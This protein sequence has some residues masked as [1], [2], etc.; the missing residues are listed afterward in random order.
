MNIRSIE[1]T[2]FENLTALSIQVWLHTY[3]KN[4]V[5]KDMAQY[6]LT[7]FTPEYFESIYYA[8][9]QKLYVATEDDHLIGFITIDLDASCELHGDLGYEIVTFYIQEYFQGKGIGKLLLDHVF[10][11]YEHKSW[12]TTW[13]HN[14]DAIGFYQHLGFQIEG[15]TYFDLDG[16]KHNNYII[17]PTH[18]LKIPFES[19]L[20]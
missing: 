1:T 14:H 13:V 7:R 6:V 9:H 19:Y 16:E 10:H 3:A 11:L 17:E 20:F 4:G 2:D 12:L 18:K 5:R 15:N 8:G